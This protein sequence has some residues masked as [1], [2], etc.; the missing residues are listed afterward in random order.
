MVSV[1]VFLALAVAVTAGALVQGAVGLGLGLVAAPVMTLVDPS[2]MP[3]VMLWLA[4]VYPVVILARDW[5]SS[6]W[7][8]LGWAFTGRVPGT[9]LGVLVVALVSTRM[10]GLLVGAMVLV[11]VV[12]TGKVI[13][14]PMRREVLVGAGV[15]SGVT[16]TATS[17]GGPPLALVYQHTSGPR[18]RA[19]LALY[20][21]GGGLLSLGGLAFAGQLDR[22]DAMVALALGPFLVVGFLLST[23]V[24]RHVDAGRTRR[25]VLAVCGASA[26][27][28]LL[29]SALG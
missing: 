19:T 8:G 15:V 14:L 16:G 13:T 9:A 18:L 22:D 10:L 20:F 28:L 17:I 4:S 25:A 2:L 6:D 3:G 7:R 24:R 29:R 5:R 11:A 23:L 27:A 1:D 26:V 21:M 12:M